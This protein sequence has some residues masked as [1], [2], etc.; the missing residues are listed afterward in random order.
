M[1][2]AV[3]LG[4]FAASSAAWKYPDCDSDNCFRALSKDGLK[5]EAE[6]FCFSW[7]SGIKTEPASIPA[8]FQNCDV[9]AASSAC[10]CITYTAT[11]TTGVA[12]TTTEAPV[13]HTTTMPTHEEPTTD[14]ETPPVEEPTTDCE[15]NPPP[16]THVEVSTTPPTTHVEVSTTPLTTHIEVSTTPLTTHIEVSTTP[17]VSHEEPHVT[18]ASSSSIMSI[19]TATSEELSTPSTYAPSSTSA[20]LTTTISLTTTEHVTTE[21]EEPTM[22]TSQPDKTTTDY[23]TKWTTSTVCTTKI[24]TITS[25]P[26]EVTECPGRGHTTI[27]TETIP[28]YTTVCPVT[29]P[30]SVPTSGMPAS[31][32]PSVPHQD[33]TTSTYLTTHTFTIT[34]CPPSVTNCPVGKVTTT[35]YP[36][37]VVTVPGGTPPAHPSSPVDVHSPPPGMPTVILPP[38]VHS[39]VT[40]SHP[41]PD[42]PHQPP[43]PSSGG[44][45]PAPSSGGPPPAESNYPSPPA[46]SHHP[47][48][49][50]HSTGGSPPSGE[51]NYPQPPPQSTGEH[52][53]PG[54]SNYPPPAQSVPTGGIPTGETPVIPT[55]VAPT[56]PNPPV[57]TAAAGRFTGSFKTV[58]A[59]AGL[60]AL[61]L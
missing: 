22:H 21:T 30:H 31:P 57:V 59:V 25:C 50:A 40:I 48:P 24:H 55:G 7:L 36:T 9:K 27:I 11:H 6:S 29:E 18:T 56:G 58:A 10:S 17:T 26:P 53:P 39:T 5:K 28:M 35:V 20:R 16:T 51:S 3:I 4:A 47:H 46:E 49:P 43:A 14:C 1:K 34:A 42:S 54:E 38:P 45:P 60:A 13:E 44:P 61:F 52:T 32:S 2:T 37:G 19:S 23:T 15:D 12:T 41:G 33:G 8:D